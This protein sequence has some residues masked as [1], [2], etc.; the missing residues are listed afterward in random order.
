VSLPFYDFKTGKR[1]ENHTSLQ[2][3]ERDV[4][5]IDSL[6]GLYPPMTS[7]V[8][9]SLK[10]RLYIE[11]LLQ[12][13]GPGGRYVRWTD[14]RLMRRMVRDASHRAYSP[15]QTLEHWHYV[16]AS[17]MRNIIAYVGTAD[18]IVNSALPYELPVMRSRLLD[19][20]R[21]WATR[22]QDDPLRWDAHTRA[23]RVRDLLESVVPAGDEAAIPPDSILREFIGGSYYNY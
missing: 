4:I 20:F 2:I 1:Q 11:P 15:H 12:M 7:S 3:G 6:H 5:L 19:D 23:V 14:L 10:F 8:D 17:E 13:K 22:Y 18:Y 16:R 21:E 9:D